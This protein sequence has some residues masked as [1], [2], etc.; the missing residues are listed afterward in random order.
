MKRFGWSIAALGFLGTAC[1][2]SAAPPAQ[3]PAPSPAPVVAPVEPKAAETK[4]SEPSASAPLPTEG[5]ET[6]INGSR[7]QLWLPVG[8]ERRTRMPA[9]VLRDPRIV[10]SF[11]EFTLDPGGSEQFLEG[12][13]EGAELK[14]SQPVMRGKLHGFV[15]HTAVDESGTRQQISGVALGKAA[16]VITVRYPEAAESLVGKMLD[17]VVLHEEEALDPFALSGMSAG[18]TAGLEVSNRVSTPILFTERGVKPPLKG[19]P[20]LAIL[21]V[22]YPKPNL[23][24][25]ELGQMLGGALV[26]YQPDTNKVK[27]GELTIGTCPA[28][29]L[30]TTGQDQGKAVVVFGMIARCP[31]SA[32]L[33]IGT[34]PVA[35]EKKML[36]RFD[37]IIHSLKLDNSVFMQVAA[38]PQ[39]ASQ[40]LP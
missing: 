19:A 24:D 11:T 1:G 17:S 10:V 8:M 13:K 7:V 34:L 12:A 23:S 26:R 37:K 4:P 33:G 28:Y 35:A 20:S 22:P 5:S 40:K 29:T 36:P 30:T 32:I 21:S 39:A 16:V 25:D 18:D 2:G 3:A 6:R 9:F 31:D 15:G 14:D 38:T 27:E